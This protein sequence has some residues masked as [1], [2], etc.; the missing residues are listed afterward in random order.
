MPTIDGY[1]LTALPITMLC[2]GQ[3]I[4]LATAFFYRSTHDLFLVSNWHVFSGRNCHTGQPIHDKGAVPDSF[5]LPLH[6]KAQL[7][8]SVFY[9]FKIV[10]ANDKPIWRQHAKGQDIDIAAIGMNMPP[11]TIE[12][13]LPRAGETGDMSLAVGMDT[14]IL[15]FPK[16]VSHHAVLPVW[17]RA[18][19][20]SEPDAILGRPDFLVDSA[21]REGMSGGPVLLRTFGG[22]KRTDGV[23]VMGTGPFTRLVGIYSGRYGGA[24]ELEAQLGR[25][26]HRS[27]IEEVVSQNNPGNYELRTV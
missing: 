17:K 9:S 7:G 10:D 18:S 26:W 20:A 5:S 4:S 1:S 21:T 15:G 16:G 3:P 8:N 2:N 14:F 19:V 24:N 25:V 13:A 6:D 12:Y 27:L 11:D 23:G 22:Y